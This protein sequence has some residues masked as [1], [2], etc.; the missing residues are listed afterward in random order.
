MNKGLQITISIGVLM[1]SFSIYYYFV[2]FQPNLEQQKRSA[3]EQR[4]VGRNICLDVA[5]NT[6]STNW[7]SVCKDFGLQ[8]NCQSPQ[9]NADT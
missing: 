1:V 3:E 6:Y 4:T 2:I 7:D 5:Q 9:Y 8:A